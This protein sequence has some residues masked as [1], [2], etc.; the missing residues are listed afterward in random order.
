MR[1]SA[2]EGD[3]E[4]G[5]Y[6]QVRTGQGRLNYRLLMDL[7]QRRKPYISILLE[8]V[9]KASAKGSARYISWKRRWG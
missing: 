2:K 9:D 3:F 7:I 6:R 8:K 4:G 5:S 1:T